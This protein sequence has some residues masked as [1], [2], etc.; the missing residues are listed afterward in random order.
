M[1]GLCSR[2]EMRNGTS[3]HALLMD[4]RCDKSAGSL[5]DIEDACRHIGYAGWLLESHGSYHFY[6]DDLVD[7]DQWLS[8]MGRWLLL[9]QLSDVRFIGHCIIERVSCLRL[10]GDEAWREPRV[11]ARVGLLETD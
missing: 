6:G 2:M 11:A 3:K 5:Q 7:E 8:F 1:I 9:E 4:F 10:T